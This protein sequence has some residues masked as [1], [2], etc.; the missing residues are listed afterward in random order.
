MQPLSL[1][2]TTLRDC[3]LRYFD[4]QAI[5]R[6]SFLRRLALLSKSTIEKERLEELVLAEGF[7]C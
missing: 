5:P 7:V 6:R 3:F 1:E 4:L 2:P